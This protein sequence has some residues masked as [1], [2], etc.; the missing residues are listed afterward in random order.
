LG[1]FLSPL[2]LYVYIV[3]WG[4]GLDGLAIT[5]A[6]LQATSLILLL[7]YCIYR[8][9]SLQGTGQQTWHGWCV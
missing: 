8:E 1:T 9:R 5:N 7:G 4:L 2:F 6:S 3:R